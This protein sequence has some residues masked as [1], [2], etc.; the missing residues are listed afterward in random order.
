MIAA[1]QLSDGSNAKYFNAVFGVVLLFTTI[2]YI[3]I[4]PAADQAAL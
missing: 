1:I 4:F 2:S 3:A